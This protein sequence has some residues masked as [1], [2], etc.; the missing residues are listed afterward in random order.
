MQYSNE[1]RRT[2]LRIAILFLIQCFSILTFSQKANPKFS[3]LTNSD[4]LSQNTVFSIVKDYKGFMWFA[5]DEGLNKYDGYKFTVYKN[6]P[7]NQGSIKTI[8]PLKPRR[9]PARKSDIGGIRE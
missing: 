8:L 1:I 3:H 6:D 7:E 5:T 4:G 2:C 9:G